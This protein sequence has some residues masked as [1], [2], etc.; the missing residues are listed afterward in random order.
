VLLRRQLL[1]L[2]VL[3]AVG[4][5]VQ[6]VLAAVDE[7][8]AQLADTPFLNAAPITIEP[9][10][11]PVEN[12]AIGSRSESRVALP[13]GAFRLVGDVQGSRR[14]ARQVVLEV[15]RNGRLLSSGRL[16]EF[17]GLELAGDAALTLRLSLPTTGSDAGDNAL[18]GLAARASFALAAA[19]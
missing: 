19:A 14:L 13:A 4:V 18:Q 8:S 11:V 2:V 6:P 1:S 9:V 17:Q 10:V 5:A 15:R 7:R 3:V 12:A 16:A